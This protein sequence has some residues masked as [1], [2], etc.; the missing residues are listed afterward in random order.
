MIP[1]PHKSK[2]IVFEGVDGSGKSEQYNRLKTFMKA[3]HPEVKVAY[4]KEP[5]I[6]RLMGAAIYEILK[7][8]HKYWKID[9]MPPYLMQ[10]FYIEDRIEDF[11]DFTIPN[12]QNGFHDL[13]DRGMASNLCYGAQT[14]SEF[15]DFLELHNRIFSAAKVP[16]I[17]PDLTLI[18]DVPAELA[19][20]RMKQGGKELDAFE[21]INKLELVRKNYYA[22]SQLPEF[23]NCKIIDGSLSVEEVFTETKK[24]V[25]PL[26]GLA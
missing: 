7:G 6:N 2:L 1:N 21:Q 9:K 5:D 11:R 4:T 25:L 15:Y 16:L 23:P 19:V 13:K 12:L 10:V 3:Y 14:T 18:Y 24:L 26:L 20:E 8:E 17:W 22:L